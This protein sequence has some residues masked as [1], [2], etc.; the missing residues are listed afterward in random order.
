M[1]ARGIEDRYRVMKHLLLTVI[2]VLTLSAFALAAPLLTSAQ[3]T[4]Q[5]A[6]V[7]AQGALLQRTAPQ[8][9][10]PL[11]PGALLSVEGRSADNQFLYVQT[12]DRQQGWVDVRALLVVN[13]SALP[14]LEMAATAADTSLPTTLLLTATTDSAAVQPPPS[15]LQATPLPATG[16]TTLVA[17][18]ISAISARVILTDSR[19]NLRGGPGIAYPVVA[20][21]EPESRWVVKGQTKAGDWLELQSPDGR[22]S[23]WAVMSY[24]VLEGSGALP[25]INDFPPPPTA[26]A[27]S[28]TLL[29]TASANSATAPRRLLQPTPV[30]DTDLSTAQTAPTL[31]ERAPGKSGLSG[32]LAL[33]DQIGGT[34][35][36]YDLN[37]D[38]LQPLTSGIDP[39][40]S[41][42][43]QRIAFTRDG[44]EGGLYLINRDGS[45]EQR[46][47][48][49]H[50]LLRAPSWSPD[51]QWIVFSRANGYED[52][53]VVRGSVCLPDETIIESLPEGLQN[54]AEIHNLVKGIPNQ[55][56]YHTS[57]A[58]IAPDGSGYRDIPALDYAAAPDWHANG[59][60]YQ[61]N[62]GIQR[63]ADEADVRSVEIAND[64]L[65][66]YFHDPD[67]QPGGGRIA[68][69]RKQG[70][71]WQ[72]Y[73]VNPDG[74]GLVALTRPVTALVDELPS[75]V[76]PAWSPDGQQ[77]IYLSNRNSIESAGAWHFWVMNADGSDQRLLP[78]DLILNY[79]FSSEQMVS[80]SR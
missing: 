8:P 49:D 12:E 7:S 76:S 56:T 2:V 24:L 74:S 37:Q 4:D 61:S 52:C 71:H 6:V 79:T 17:T 23:G 43:G 58:R 31:Q 32:T 44:G 50:P 10:L 68:F 39:A 73:A 14:I 38:T 66:G 18:P 33:Q 16:E 30:A 20:K 47:Y 63:T 13:V 25:V 28:V 54:D 41:P 53:R 75:N 57:L 27:S 11:S 3:S 1:D 48:N 78:I 19:L 55:R 46:I 69:H 80:W 22:A 15:I 51:G 29:P 36:L 64:P 65:V 9:L 77:I 70:S 40:I 60:V 34:I 42:D 59:I 21:A 5:I 35:Y 72:I 62:A 45:G 26:S 67:W